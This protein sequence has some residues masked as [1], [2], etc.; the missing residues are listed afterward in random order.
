[1]ARLGMKFQAIPDSGARWVNHLR[2]V[3]PF[4]PKRKKRGVIILGLHYTFHGL[5]TPYEDPS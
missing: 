4:G 3:H 1:M 5:Q 2:V